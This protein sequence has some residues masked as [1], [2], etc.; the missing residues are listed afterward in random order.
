MKRSPA[1]ASL[2]RTLGPL[3]AAALV[4]SNVIGVGI[5]TTPGIVAELVPRP[6]PF[7][8]VWLAGGALALAGAFSYAELAVHRPRA[9]GEY[10]YLKEASVPWPPS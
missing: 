3:D 4:I 2:S 6:L 8:A 10:V 9:G 5:F 1:P 7:L